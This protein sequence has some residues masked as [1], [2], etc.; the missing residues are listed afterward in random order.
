MHR[1][2]LALLLSAATA[3]AVAQAPLGP[4]S[5]GMSYGSYLGG[6]LTDR[7]KA[8]ASCPDGGIVFVGS[9]GSNNFPATPGAAQPNRRGLT[10]SFVAKL[11][12]AG[13][14]EWATYLG[15]TDASALVAESAADVAV[16]SDGS[17][18]VVGTTNGNDFPVTPGAAQQMF[19]GKLNAYAAR[20]NASG[21]LLWAT[22]LGG[23]DDDY[24]SAVALDAQGR[25]VV[26][27]R[28]FSQNFPVTRGAY[29]ETENSL[30]FLF[31]DAWALRLSANGSVIEWATYM[32]G[33]LRDEANDVA[34]ADDGS[35][36]V[37]GLS[38][39]S[40]FPVSAG[41]FDDSYNGASGS[42]T[43][44]FLL[45]L[46][47]AG[48]ALL[49]ATFFGSTEIVEAQALALDAQGRPVIAGRTQGDDLPGTGLGFQAHYAGGES[50]GF[51]AGFSADGSSLRFA[52]YVGGA[53]RDVVL[54][55]ALSDVGQP[56]LVGLTDSPDFPVRGLQLNGHA[57]GSGAGASGGVV[58]PK[59]PLVAGPGS[60][61][62]NPEQ[63]F[64]SSGDN[65]LS[66]ALDGFVLRTR[67]AGDELVAG[68]FVGG[69]G[70]EETA[71]LAHDGAG[72]VLVTGYTNSHDLDV[73][74]NAAQA[75]LVAADDAF[76]QRLSLPPV[77]ALA[78]SSGVSAG[79]PD[80]ARTRLHVASSLEPGAAFELRV[81]ASPEAEQV[82]LLVGSEWQPRPGPGGALL[83]GGVASLFAL[84]RRASSASLAE[85]GLSLRWPRGVPADTQLFLQAITRTRAGWSV[86]DGVL[87][88]SP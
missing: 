82:F 38:G 62:V 1:V 84:P 88:V 59:Q 81:E 44:A 28:T 78:S 75:A 23:S 6:G 27:G 7:A 17:V 14:L 45:R 19:P 57:R 55:L 76:V 25:A 42:K 48:D 26:V 54:D 70:N 63:V 2:L 21:T 8:V 20:F 3:S 51:L 32:G 43:D 39:S 37:A 18:T 47:P 68:A 86:G 10:D 85:P 31:N 52:S 77:I 12:V 50:D 11:N 9:T 73:S 46:S 61:F 80:R 36:F 53:G 58:G 15:A 71:G 5:L 33:L 41:A 60:G 66:G 30:N 13:E 16:G 65:D 4:P 79:S 72:R 22:Y 74:A 29:D 40:N 64:G 35:V 24:A 34:V 69:G 67:R 49:W 83:P 87:L 56:T